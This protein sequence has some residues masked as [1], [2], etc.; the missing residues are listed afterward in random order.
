[1]TCPVDISDHLSQDTVFP[2]LAREQS[3]HG[4]RDGGYIWY[5]QNGLLLTTAD[6]AKATPEY[7]ICQ[8]QGSTP[9]TR[10]GSIPWREQPGTL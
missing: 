10:Y 8:K 9:N 6:L 4:C 5:Q 1:M 7:L 2:L 3:G